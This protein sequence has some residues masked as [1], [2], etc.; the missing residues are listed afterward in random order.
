MKHQMI[1]EKTKTGFSAYSPDVL[2]CA[3]TGKTL[4]ETEKTMREALEFHFEGLR[5]G[6]LEIPKPSA[7][8]NYVEIAA[9]S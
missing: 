9:V 2:G 5:L 4:A 1:T 8:A 6:N 7:H 3:A